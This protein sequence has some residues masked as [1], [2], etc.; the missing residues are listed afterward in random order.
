VERTVAVGGELRSHKGLNLPGI[1]LGIGVFAAHDS[2]CLEFALGA[3]VDAVSQSFVDHAADIEAV[4]SAAAK[5][6]SCPR[7]PATRRAPFRAASRPCGFVAPGSDPAVC[8]GLAFS[9]GVHPVD[10]A[11]EPADCR[12]YAARWLPEHGLPADRVML[13]AGPSP[14]NPNASHRLE[15]M[16]EAGRP[17]IH[18]SSYASCHGSA[19]AR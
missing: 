10:L 18:C 19:C 4:R 7:S 8:Q 2:A 12:E 1:D 3:G 5:P 6:C 11:E 15:L 17:A 9:Y 14:R 13:V 16:R